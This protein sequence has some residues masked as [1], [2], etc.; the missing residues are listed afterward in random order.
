MALSLKNAKMVGIG[1]LL[2]VMTVIGAQKSKT[3]SKTKLNNDNFDQNLYRS[4]F[5]SDNR[6]ISVYNE[7]LLPSSVYLLRRYLSDHG[8]WEHTLKDYN[9]GS[10]F[11]EESPDHILWK[12]FLDP[13]FMEKTKVGQKVIRAVRHFKGKQDVDN[14]HIYH[15]AA[16]IVVRSELP[17]SSIDTADNN[18]DVSA[19]VYLTGKWQKNDYGDII[20]YENNK[21]IVCAV[22]PVM[23]RMVMFDSSI[24]HLYKPP[25][26]DHSGPLRTIHFKLTSSKDKL[27]RAIQDYQKRTQHR[28][29]TRNIKLNDIAPLSSPRVIQVQQHITRQFVAPSG[30]KIYV[31]DNVFTPSELEKLRQ[32]VEYKE[33]VHQQYLDKG[34]D[35]VSWLAN[36]SLQDFVESNLWKIHQQV[37]NH[38]GSRH[39]YFPYDISCNMIKNTDNTRIH[40]DCSLA[41]DQWTMVTYLNPNWTAQ[42]GGETAFFEK[43]SHEDNNYVIQVRPRYGRSVIFQSTIYHSARPP[44]NLFDGLRYSFSVK[45]AEDEAQARLN[46]LTEDFVIYASNLDQCDSIARIG[47]KAGTKKIEKEIL[48]MLTAEDVIVPAD[49]DREEQT[50]NQDDYEEGSDEEDAD[51]QSQQGNSDNQEETEQGIHYILIFLFYSYF[52]LFIHVANLRMILSMMFARITLTLYSYV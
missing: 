30:K 41:A 48:G 17:K 44:A 22:H 11:R 16:K 3:S 6:K 4:F 33:Y 45:M 20:F 37:V 29:Q 34:S 28:R 27:N 50:Q 5:T 38:F 12:T 43:N 13:Q 24:E 31:L 15:A 46:R 10:N 25:S 8:R 52:D 18:G 23:F 39:S 14:Y 21:E 7:F 26:I 32:I 19:I 47:R 42:M 2:L 1:L 36:F 35:G 49:D 9:N 40:T 51:Q